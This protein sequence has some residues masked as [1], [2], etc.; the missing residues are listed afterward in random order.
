MY[1]FEYLV[2]LSLSTNEF[3][4]AK[5]CL[6]LSHMAQCMLVTSSAPVNRVEKETCMVAS[7]TESVGGENW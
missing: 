7:F 5:V 2:N 3:K 6:M 1:T 4:L